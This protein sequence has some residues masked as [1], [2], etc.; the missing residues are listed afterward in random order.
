MA[1]THPRPVKKAGIL[2]LDR[3]L[4]CR[5]RIPDRDLSE[6]ALRSCCSQECWAA[7]VRREE[8]KREKRRR[9]LGLA[10]LAV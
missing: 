2:A 10:G 5:R 3:C 9:R 1:R 8:R 6:W 7:D 4:V